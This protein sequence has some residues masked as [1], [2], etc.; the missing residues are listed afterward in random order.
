VQYIIEAAELIKGDI[1]FMY[2]PSCIIIRDLFIIHSNIHE[3]SPS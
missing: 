3:P 2:D 1:S